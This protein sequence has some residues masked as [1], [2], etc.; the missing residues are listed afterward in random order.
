[1]KKINITEE[2]S[3]GGEEKRKTQRSARCAIEKPRAD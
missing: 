2:V 3:S 1:M